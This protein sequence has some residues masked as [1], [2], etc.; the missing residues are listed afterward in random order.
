[1]KRV[2]SIDT[3]LAAHMSGIDNASL[4]AIEGLNRDG[5]GAFFDAENAH[6]AAVEAASRPT[7]PEQ[8]TK[9]DSDR[10]VLTKV[11]RW[12]NNPEE[13]VKGIITDARNPSGVL[14]EQ[15]VKPVIDFITQHYERNRNDLK[16]GR[17]SYMS[18]IRDVFENL[19]VD[20]LTDAQYDYF[21]R[22]RK[23]YEHGGE[24]YSANPQ[25]AL[26]KG[27]SNLTGNIIKSSP[28]VIL[29][30]VMEGVVKLPTLYPKT[31]LEGLADAFQYGLKRV[32]EIENRGGYGFNYQ[33]QEDSWAGLIG[34]TDVPL[35]NALYFAAKRAGE[36]GLQGIQKGAF[37]PRLGDLPSLY[38]DGFG[39]ASVSLLGYTIG[40]YKMYSSL[41]QEAKKGNLLPLVTYHVMAGLVGGGVAA[42][43][44]KPIEELVK[45]VAPDSE[46]FFENNK[47]P[48]AKLVQPGGID[49]LGVQ[50][51]IGKRQGERFLK[52]GGKSLESFRDGDLG[53]AVMNG[54]DAGLYASAFANIPFVSD[55][56]AQKVFRMGRDVATGEL[57]LEDVPERSA[58]DL[59]PFLKAN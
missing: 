38:Y 3:A 43:L 54:A 47:G 27:F 24:L 29:G 57:E 41:F 8:R 30:N 55:I 51:E 25:T 9:V 53:G 21:Q 37:T 10:S 59:A 58:K 31:A 15:T 40:T 14:G 5:R 34:L 2:C 7:T 49:R 17:A 46:E 42:G 39:R 1:M 11:A 26:S 12:A 44:P 45:A 19:K 6:G 56:N 4:G 23:H 33:G 18:G 28:N 36:D 35:K 20:H 13:L 50:F 32:P 48:M 52:A 16:A 22:Y